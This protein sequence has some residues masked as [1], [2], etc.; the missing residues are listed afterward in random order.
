M[1]AACLAIAEL[2]T[3]E[4]ENELGACRVEAS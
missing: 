3:V 1:R 2:R 4:A